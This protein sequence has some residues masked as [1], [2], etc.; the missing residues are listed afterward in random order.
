MNNK[1]ALITGATS[2]IGKAT[3]LLFA[4]NGATVIL[5]GRNEPSGQELLAEITK[6]NG[7]GLFIQT[8]IKNPLSIEALIKQTLEKFG[9][10]DYAINNAG[11]EGSLVHLADT[12]EADWD[13]VINTNLKGLW[14]C[15]KHEIPALIQSGGGSIVNI[16]T[17]LTKYSYATTAIYTASKAGVE[18]LGRIAATEYGQHGIRINTICPGAVDTPMLRR[19]FKEEELTN[20][21]ESNPL[22]K[23]ATPEDIAEAIFWICTTSHINGSCLTIDGGA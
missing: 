7:R 3:A 19:I 21:K 11:V 8:D 10:L 12:T 18:A 16:S 1:I 13:D 15:M 22:K 17:N 6:L 4:K 20:L 23:I 5:A 2:G 14:L 9:R